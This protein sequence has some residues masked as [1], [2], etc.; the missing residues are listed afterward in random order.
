[1]PM[2]D[3]KASK[4]RKMGADVGQVRREAFSDGILIKYGSP[5]FGLVP[6]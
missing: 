1:M 4:A 5:D 2:Y 3:R 6:A